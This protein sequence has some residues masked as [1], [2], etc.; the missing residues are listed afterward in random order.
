M[1]RQHCYLQACV[2]RGEPL[3]ARRYWLPGN[4]DLLAEAAA[5]PVMLAAKWSCP[6]AD[7]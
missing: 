5:T 4:K 7:A 3:H 2:C 1:P 6:V